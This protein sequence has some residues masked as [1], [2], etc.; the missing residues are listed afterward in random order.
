MNAPVIGAEAG[1]GGADTWSAALSWRYQKS[2]RHFRGSEEESDRKAENSEVINRI[3]FTELAITRNFTER[4][5]LTVGIP[6][7]MMERS[8]A[9]RDPSLPDN[10]FGNDPVVDRTQT[11][12]RGLGDITVVPH[13]WAFE[14]GTHPNYNLS[15]GLGI[16]LPT[17]EDT[18]EDTFQVRVDTPGTT[19]EPFR[20]TNVVRTVDQSIQ[21]GDGGL[22]WILDVQGFYRFGRG[23]GATY[24]TATYLANPENVSEGAT[25]RG[26]DAALSGPDGDP[27]PGSEA[28]FSVADQYLYRVGATWFPSKKVGL[29]LGGRW[30]GVPT[31]DLIGDSNGFRRPGYAFSIEPGVS[32]TTGPHT[33]SLLV[34]FAE[35]RNRKQSVPDK[36]DDGHGDAAFADY[37]IIAGYFRRF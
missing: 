8:Q 21:P 7:M 23:K 5:S 4:F 18:V 2:D 1:Y 36:E 16:K 22:G 15:L 17:G 28:F 27:P 10:E 33:F 24:L 13:W 30:E 6:Y 34:P 25:W 31:E 32:F 20:E 19:S 35:H 29:S 9:L 14:P 12:A 37:L 11:Q 26:G 3:Y